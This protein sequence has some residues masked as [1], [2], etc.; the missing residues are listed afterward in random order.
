MYSAAFIFEP[1]NYN[2]AFYTLDAQIHQIAES[3]DGFLGR[4]LWRSLDGS[5]TNATYYWQSLEALKA[6]SQ[7][8]KHL[9]AKRQYKQ[10]YKGFHVVISKIERSYGDGHI[11]HITPSNRKPLITSLSN[12]S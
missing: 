10:W 4:E 8:E 7:N 5:I 1:G 3:M 12:S 9:E 6:F 2:D 11:A